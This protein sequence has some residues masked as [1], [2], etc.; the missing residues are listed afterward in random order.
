MIETDAAGIAFPGFGEHEG[1]CP[2]VSFNRGAAMDL[3]ANPF[4]R[5]IKAGKP[6]IG[7][8]LPQVLYK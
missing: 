4:K 3:P 6:Q 5:A 8:W 7:L 1:A 2:L